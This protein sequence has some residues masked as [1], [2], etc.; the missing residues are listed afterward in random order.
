MCSFSISLGSSCT[1]N[2]Q[3]DELDHKKKGMIQFE[4]RLLMTI[5]LNSCKQDL[6]ECATRLIALGRQSG[7]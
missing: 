1:N 5:Y 6:L 7:V 4:M 3:R 2:H